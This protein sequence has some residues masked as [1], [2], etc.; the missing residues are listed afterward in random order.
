MV[1]YKFLTV[2]K[3]TSHCLIYS[4]PS[5]LYYFA[6]AAVTKYSTLGG[7]NNEIY[8]LTFLEP[9]SPSLR[10]WQSWLHLKAMRENL[11]HASSLASGDLGP[12]FGISCLVEASSQSLPST[13]HGVLF[14]CVV[15]TKFTLFIRTSVRLRPTLMTSF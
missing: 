14:V 2:C 11:V 7:L 6:R 3:V 4:E 10:C 15:V 12:V 1:H 13:I 5:S 8:Y 9:G